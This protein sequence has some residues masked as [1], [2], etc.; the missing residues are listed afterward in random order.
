MGFL[1]AKPAQQLNFVEP[2]EEKIT[3]FG[4]PTHSY[5]SK[6]SIKIIRMGNFL[7]KEN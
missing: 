6:F 2:S 4:D 1:R 3:V 7:D 5:S